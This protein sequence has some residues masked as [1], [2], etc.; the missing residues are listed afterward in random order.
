MKLR[1][2]ES[3]IKLTNA[4]R[5]Q[6]EELTPKQIAFAEHLVNNILLLFKSIDNIRVSVSRQ[7]AC[8]FDNIKKAATKITTAITIEWAFK[9]FIIYLNSSTLKYQI[10]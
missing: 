2:P 3:P 9:Y 6:R 8:H 5:E 7:T 10:K 4:L 1:S